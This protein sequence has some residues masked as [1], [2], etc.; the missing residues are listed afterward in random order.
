MNSVIP[1]YGVYF[2]PQEKEPC[3]YKVLQSIP[4]SASPIDVGVGCMPRGTHVAVSHR[5]LAN[6][7]QGLSYFCEGRCSAG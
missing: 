5:I 2:V 1:V 6:A 3:G 4:L 7:K